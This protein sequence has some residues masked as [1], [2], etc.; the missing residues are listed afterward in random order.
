[1]ERRIGKFKLDEIYCGDALELMK[2]IP[3]N[4]IDLIITDPPFAIDFKAK[5]SNYNRDSNKVLEGYNEIPKEKYYEFSYNWMKEAYRILKPTGSMYVFSGWTNLKDILNALD[6]VGFITINHIIWKYQFGVYTKKRFVTSHY[7]ILFV[8]KDEKK[9]KFNK[10]EHYPE[11][12]W[13]INR[14][15]WKGEIKTPTKL[16]LK[17]VEK[18]ILYSS[19]EGDVVFDPFIGSGTVAVCAKR[20]NRHFLGFEIVPEYVQLAKERLKEIAPIKTSLF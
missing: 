2:D 6:D 19:D 16:P 13:I 9:Y 1:M 10:I 4:T 18:I 11:D 12:V 5:R 17:L 3:D 14:E 15:Y 8:V 20:L 7:H